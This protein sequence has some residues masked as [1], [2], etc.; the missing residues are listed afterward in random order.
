MKIN[1]IE[2]VMPQ[3][4]K[5]IELFSLIKHHIEQIQFGNVTFTVSVKNGKITMM[6]KIREEETYSFDAGK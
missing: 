4:K 5:E 6:R 2:Q 3:D 1:N